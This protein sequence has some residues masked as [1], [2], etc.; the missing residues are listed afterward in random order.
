[1]NE[2]ILVVDDEKNIRELIK[3]NLE[4]EGFIVYT[5]EDGEQALKELDG[6][7]DLVFSFTGYYVTR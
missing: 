3:F 2:K 1:M 7:I 6:S 4:K 5:V